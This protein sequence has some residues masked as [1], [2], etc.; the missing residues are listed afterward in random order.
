MERNRSIVR[1]MIERS[2]GSFQNAQSTPM[3]VLTMFDETYLREKCLDVVFDADNLELCKIEATSFG[4]CLSRSINWK[5]IGSDLSEFTCIQKEPNEN[6]R[7]PKYWRKINTLPWLKLMIADERVI[8]EQVFDLSK[9]YRIYAYTGKR[10]ERPLY[11]I[12]IFCAKNKEYFTYSYA[13][14]KGKD[15][16][17]KIIRRN[18]SWCAKCRSTPLF[19]IREYH[20]SYDW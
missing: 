9:K 15:V 3:N 5:D 19:V 13:L 14:T 20:R 16:L 8:D 2:I 11:N 6:V 7:A 4:S 17:Y 18:Y 10:P 1:K 12:C